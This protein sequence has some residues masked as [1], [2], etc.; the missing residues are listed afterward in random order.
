MIIYIQCSDHLKCIHSGYFTSC[1]RSL[2][3]PTYCEILWHTTYWYSIFVIDKSMKSLLVIMVIYFCAFQESHFTTML[4][5]YTLINFFLWQCIPMNKV[6]GFYA[7]LITLKPTS[8]TACYFDVYI[9][10]SSV[11]MLLLRKIK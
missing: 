3:V 10:L 7:L 1:H 6:K 2:K 11:T 8:L 4:S 5:A 9:Q